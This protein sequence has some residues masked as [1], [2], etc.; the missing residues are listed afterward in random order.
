MPGKQK[1]NTVTAI[2]CS[3][4]LTALLSSVSPVTGAGETMLPDGERVTGSRQIREA[5][6]THPTGRY[7]HGIVGDAVEAGGLSVIL[8]DGSRHR[9]LP[10][11]R[12][13]F[14]DR[15]P[16]LADLDD[17]GEDEIYLVRSYLERGAAMAVYEVNDG[18]LR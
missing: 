1:S 15:Y 4:I 13:V 11:K 9:L 10:D 8:R 12:S 7:R 14:E 2:L 17:D 16:C 5:W 6:L 3:S 18:G